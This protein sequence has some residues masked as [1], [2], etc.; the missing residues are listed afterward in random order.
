MEIFMKVNGSEISMKEEV[1]KLWMEIDMTVSLLITYTTVMEDWWSQA[2]MFTRDSLRMA[3][4]ADK[5]NK[6]GKMEVIT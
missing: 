4:N 5:E 2:E 3:F 1:F 6:T